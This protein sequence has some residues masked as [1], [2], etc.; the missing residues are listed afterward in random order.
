MINRPRSL[1]ADPPAGQRGTLEISRRCS[2]LRNCG[3]WRPGSG[4]LTGRRRQLLQNFLQRLHLPRRITEAQLVLTDAVAN[5]SMARGDHRFAMAA[6]GGK[7]RARTVKAV[8][9]GQDHKISGGI[10]ALDDLL[11]IEPL[12]PFET[13]RWQCGQPGPQGLGILRQSS[14]KMKFDRQILRVRSINSTTSIK[15][16]RSVCRPTTST[17][18]QPEGS[19]LP[20]S[21]CRGTGA[22]SGIHAKRSRRCAG[23]PEEL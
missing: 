13:P 15:P 2:P 21:S 1:A 12:G 23:N 14:D 9:I 22:G 11:R 8:R 6:R 3:R 7:H 17:V 4:R 20:R 5:D 16:L 18:G 19:A 10:L